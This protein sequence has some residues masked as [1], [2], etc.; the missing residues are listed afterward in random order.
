MR[1][2]SRP[3]TSHLKNILQHE[4][5]HPRMVNTFELYWQDVT[6]CV[7]IINGKDYQLHAYLA[8]GI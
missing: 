1:G 5:L 8:C 6:F 2:D 7:W 3:S 4:T